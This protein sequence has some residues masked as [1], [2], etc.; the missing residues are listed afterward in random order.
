[1]TATTIDAVVVGSGPN[2]PVAAILLA[3]AGR[4]VV[5]LEAE[6]TIGG[7]PRSAELMLPGFVHGICSAI[8][9]FGAG[10]PVVASLPLAEHGL[11]WLHP[12]VAIAH[13][14]DGGRAGLVSRDAGETA[15]GLG[16][17]GA[18]WFRHIASQSAR[19]VM[20]LPMLLRPL[21]QIPR[22]P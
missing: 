16:T 9:P 6:P 2:G 4:S 18:S 14:L 12:S 22:H 15:T 17:D 11:R 7:G 19:W 3:M 5:V 13:P 20:L 10:S 8:H 1:M 21:P